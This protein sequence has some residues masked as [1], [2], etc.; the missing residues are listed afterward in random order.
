MI[1]PGECALA[2]V[3]TKARLMIALTRI[4]GSA[5]RLSPIRLLILKPRSM[6]M[7]LKEPNDLIFHHVDH[8]VGD[9]VRLKV[10]TQRHAPVLAGRTRPRV[11]Q[12]ALPDRSD[13]GRIGILEFHHGSIELQHVAG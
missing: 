1:S 11:Q 6:L 3:G 4:T 9:A 8:F 12:V 2:G 13:H 5:F 7:L 10:T